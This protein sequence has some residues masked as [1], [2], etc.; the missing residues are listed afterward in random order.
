[1]IGASGVG[2]YL[3]GI[4]P[5]LSRSGHNFLLLGNRGKLQPFAGPN[6]TTIEC[7][8]KTF[9]VRELFFFPGKILQKINTSDFFYSPFF[10]VPGGIRVPVYTTIHDMIFPDMPHLTSRVGLA[11]RMWFYRRAFAKS[12]KI[13][14]VSEFSKSRI[15]HYSRKKVPVFVTNISVQP[16]L[17]RWKKDGIRK[18]ETIIFIGNIK[19]HKGL[20]LLLEA[21]VSAKA[22]GLPHKLVIIGNRENFRTAD[23]LFMRKVDSLDPETVT[24]YES[25]NN[26]EFAEYLMQASLLVQPSLYEGF[27]LPPLEAM[28]LGT[29]ALISDIPVFREIYG[30]FPVTFFRAG[31]SG[32]LKEKM[33]E[34]LLKQNAVS[35]SLP[36][37]LAEKYTF[38]KTASIVLKNLISGE[39]D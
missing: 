32:D 38:E 15:E 13:F 5:W 2:V 31:D 8:I 9:S 28:V 36:E 34:I 35:F 25:G 16:E 39:T 24:F 6:I 23:N 27:G 20:N 29:R 33:L 19:K 22:Q 37:H 26:E 11:A 18:K 10:N 4:L 14:T 1:M 17:L 7:N 12:R 30:E 3:R 21:F